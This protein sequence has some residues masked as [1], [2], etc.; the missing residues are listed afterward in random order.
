[1]TVRHVRMNRQAVDVT[2]LDEQEGSDLAYWLSR[3]AAERIEALELLR[4]VHFG[5]DPARDCLLRAAKV[6]DGSRG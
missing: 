4:Q 6:V 5:Y 1:M 2:S 3:T